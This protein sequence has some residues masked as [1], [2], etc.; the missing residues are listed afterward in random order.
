[1]KEPTVRELPHIDDPREAIKAT[2]TGPVV[3]GSTVLGLPLV[4]HFPEEEFFT[5]EEE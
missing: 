2:E 1:M 3:C 5:I 4:T